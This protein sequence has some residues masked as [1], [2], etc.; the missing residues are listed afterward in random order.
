MHSTILQSTDTQKGEYCGHDIINAIIDGFEKELEFSLLEI[1]LKDC[2]QYPIN[3]KKELIGI[4]SALSDRYSK[5][6]IINTEISIEDDIVYHMETED[7]RDIPNPVL[8]E[9]GYKQITFHIFSGLKIPRLKPCAD[10][11]I[12]IEFY[13]L[14]DDTQNLK[15][16]TCNY[17]LEYE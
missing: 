9:M 2:P 6:D 14:I 7:G 10:V 4:L 13:Y 8:E 3:Q 17:R 5:E 1:V 16:L 15:S 12:G 11:G